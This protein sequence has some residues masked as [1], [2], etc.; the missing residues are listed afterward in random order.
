M[1]YCQ[2][3]VSLS[4]LHRLLNT[5]AQA[6]DGNRWVQPHIRKE[7]THKMKHAATSQKQRNQMVEIAMI[8]PLWLVIATCL[9]FT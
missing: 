3:P 1:P 8:I 5:N 9:T 4:G 2:F 7:N 6:R